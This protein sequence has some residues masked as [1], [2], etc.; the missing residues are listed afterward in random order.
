MEKEYWKGKRKLHRTPGGSVRRLCD[1][2]RP[3]DRP[4][5]PHDDVLVVLLALMSLD[6]EPEI[7]G[8][9][10][11]DSTTRVWRARKILFRFA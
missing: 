8:W 3:L 11:Q 9:T 2:H 1:P 10:R 5:R 4:H 7:G 6:V